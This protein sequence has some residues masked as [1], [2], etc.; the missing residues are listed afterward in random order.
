MSKTY[1]IE[2]GQTGVSSIHQATVG[3]YH[4]VTVTPPD[5]VP[6]Y[7]GTTSP[8]HLFLAALGTCINL[9]FEVALDRGRIDV[10]DLTSEVEGTYETNDTT[11]KSYF[12]EIRVK[13]RVIVPEEMKEERIRKLF[14]IALNGCPIGNTLLGSRVKIVPELDI[15][16]A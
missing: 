6:E 12:T 5:M 10:I 8:H 15:V 13:T 1:K 9:V 3:P 16:Y 7:P 4:T 11:R 2:L 14:E